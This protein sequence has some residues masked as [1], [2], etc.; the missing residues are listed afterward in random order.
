LKQIGVQTIIY[1]DISRDGVGGGVNLNTTVELVQ[2][3]GLDVIASGG[4]YSQEDVSAVKTAGLSGVIIGRAL[5]EQ[6]IDPQ[7]VFNLQE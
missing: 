1:T 5:Y 7:T 2:K 6:S 4:I 3:S